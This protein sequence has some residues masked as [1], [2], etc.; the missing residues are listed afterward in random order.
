MQRVKQIRVI[1]MQLVTTL[2]AAFSVFVTWG[3]QEMD[4]TAQVCGDIYTYAM[5]VESL[6][7]A[8]LKE[9]GRFHVVHA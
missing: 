6:M 1:T 3:S 7:V 9:A 2:E 5:Y 8:V 4:W